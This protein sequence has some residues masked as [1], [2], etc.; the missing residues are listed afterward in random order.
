MQV[1]F[2][3]WK[4]WA[5]WLIGCNF[6]MT[7][8]SI[9]FSMLACS[10]PSKVIRQVLLQPSQRCTRGGSCQHLSACCAH[11][12]AAKNGTFLCSGSGLQHQRQLGNHWLGSEEA[13]PIFSSRTSCFSRSQEMLWWAS[14]TGAATRLVVLI[15]GLNRLRLSGLLARP[16]SSRIKRLK[17]F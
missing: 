8:A 9:M 16:F 1:C 13:T 5:Q 14:S 3:C 15:R 6:Q 11:D 2:R 17:A 7:L 12:Y 4:G 10:N